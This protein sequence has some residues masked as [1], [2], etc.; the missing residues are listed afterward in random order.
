MTSLDGAAV[1]EL[2]AGGAVPSMDAG[3]SHSQSA[4]GVFYRPLCRRMDKPR[5]QYRC[6]APT[7]VT[8]WSSL[9]RP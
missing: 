6:C 8:A 2:T 7:E 1:G 4:L 3:P 5:A 9:S